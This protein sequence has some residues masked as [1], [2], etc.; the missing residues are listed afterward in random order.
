MPHGRPD[1]TSEKIFPNGGVVR[2]RDRANVWPLSANSSKM[3]KATDFKF[4][5][6]PIKHLFEIE[7]SEPCC[8]VTDDIT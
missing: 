2:S 8:H 1:M 6:V 7:Y 4:V 3:V 5:L